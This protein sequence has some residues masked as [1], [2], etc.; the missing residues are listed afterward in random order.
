MTD[1]GGEPAATPVTPL[2]IFAGVLGMA[3]STALSTT[4]S[5]AAVVMPAATLS[6]GTM[7]AVSP[8]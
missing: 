1:V 8:R 7:L 4:A 3:R 5:I 2:P 6:I